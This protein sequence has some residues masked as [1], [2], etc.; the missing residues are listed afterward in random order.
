LT[1]AC[2]ISTL[3][4]FYGATAPRGPG[5]PH[6]RGFTVTL[7]HTALGRTPLDEWSARRRDL[8]LQTHNIH[9]K[10]TSIPPEECAPTIP[11]RERP[12]T[13][14]LDLAVNG[15]RHNGKFSNG[16]FEVR[17][18]RHYDFGYIYKQNI[19]KKKTVFRSFK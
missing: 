14:A 5:P 13:Q 11:K 9:K 17:V 6:C 19:V 15:D 10:H 4:F 1:L 7:R 18:F 12:Q 2:H 16:H 8:Y 3:V